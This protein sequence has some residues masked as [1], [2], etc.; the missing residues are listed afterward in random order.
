MDPLLDQ[1][2]CGYFSISD[3]GII[4]FANRTLA[5]MLGLEREDMLG[6]HIESYLSNT[7]K[8]FFHTY[9][10]PFMQLYGHVNEMYLSLRSS[11]QPD[12][13]VLLNGARQE[14]EGET[15]TVCVVVEMRKRLEHEKDILE[16]K[17]RLEQLVQETNEANRK[18]ELLHR[19]YE[20]KQQELLSMNLQLETLALTDP[21]TGLKNRRF[22]QESLLAH[23]ASFR[24]SQAPFSILLIDID[25]FKSINDTYGHPVGDL[26]LTELARLL[27]A[28]SRETDVVARFGG[29]EFIV[30]LEGADQTSSVRIAE[31]YRAAIEATPMGKLNI[32]ASMGVATMTAE[33]T[34]ETLIDRADQALYQSK[35]NGRNRVTSL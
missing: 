20:A 21:L 10:Y 9:F 31:R 5:N 27:Q 15:V 34:S 29:E 2:P 4:R 16:T 25:R 1:A 14:H 7:N 22:F 35:E 28:S 18:L 32:T 17:R 6:K 13:P 26:V 23:I 11:S 8:L 33:D 19:E 24:R 30:L 12:V 3:T